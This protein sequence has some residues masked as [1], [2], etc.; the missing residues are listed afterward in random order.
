MHDIPQEVKLQSKSE[1][2]MPLFTRYFL[3]CLNSGSFLKFLEQ[4]TGI[5]NLIGD[6]QFE[7]GGLH[8]I[9][10]GGKLAIHA[11]FN[12][13]SCFTLDRRLNMLIYLNKGWKEEYGGHFELW[14]RSMS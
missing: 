6:P 11:D 14:N 13:H 5:R 10:S 7:G 3:Y 12:K 8:Q 1:Q 4:L 2:D 9:V